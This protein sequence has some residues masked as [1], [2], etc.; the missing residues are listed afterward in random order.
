LLSQIHEPALE[1]A[2]WHQLGAVFQEQHQ[3]QEAE[4]HYL[5]AA[6][7]REQHGQLAAAR[8]SRNVEFGEGADLPFQVTLDEEQI[9]DYGLDGDLLV[10]GPRERRVTRWASEP[11]ALT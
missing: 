2:A 3:R 1:A 6:R 7:I 10:D 8:Q 4:R 9:T 5:E 11:D